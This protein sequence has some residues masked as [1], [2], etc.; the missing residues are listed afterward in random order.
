MK[1]ALRFR[2]FFEGKIR[3][4]FSGSEPFRIIN[5]LA[6]KDIPV[7]RIVSEDAAA[8][9]LYMPACDF[10]SIRSA[11]RKLSLRAHII[12]KRGFFRRFFF[13]RERPVL[14]A[15][16]FLLAAAVFL[17]SG[18]VWSVRVIP[19]GGDDRLIFAKLS[20]FGIYPGARKT[21]INEDRIKAQLILEFP[22]LVWAG[23]FTDG[24]AVSV[25]YELR[26]AAPDIVPAD[27]PASIY[28]AKNGVIVKLDVFRGSAVAERGSTVLR[29]EKIVSGEVK[30]GEKGAYGVHA[31]ADIEA[32][33]WYT[34]EGTAA[35]ELLCKEYT[36][37]EKAEFYL[38]LGKKRIKITQG[39]GIPYAF[40][41]KITYRRC[42]YSGGLPIYIICDRYI[43]Y[44]PRSEPA[45]RRDFIR[46]GMTE[47]L[48]ASLKKGR[49]VSS[50]FTDTEL[51]VKMYCECLED[52]G[53]TAAD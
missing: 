9:S 31:L 52:I 51:G 20:E 33:T 8:L 18:F 35:S 50:L 5:A 48:S 34:L 19:N 37:A 16:V 7:R 24:S 25:T 53:I 44:I 13:L 28:A 43:E 42:E 23:I 10:P 38:Q 11:T 26:E 47:I 46:E 27:L 15:G 14:I 6:E 40:Y 32:R 29:G 3:V 36:G 41:D 49:I 17:L 12:Q 21:R 45:D 30:F 2:R 4:R 1:T 22:E 39:T